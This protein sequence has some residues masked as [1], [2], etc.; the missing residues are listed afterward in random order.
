MHARVVLAVGK[1]VLFREASSV[2]ECH[3]YTVYT[4]FLTCHE[5]DSPH[6]LLNSDLSHRRE[7][8]VGVVRHYYTTEQHRHY[9]CTVCVCVYMYN[10]EKECVCVCA[11]V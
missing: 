6:G 11:C 5:R 8:E 2:Q 10:E 7:V 4:V 1:R 3:L 9:P